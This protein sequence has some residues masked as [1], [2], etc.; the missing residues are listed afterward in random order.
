MR[1]LIHFFESAVQRFETAVQRR[2]RL[3]R[4]L[5]GLLDEQP[6]NV[7]KVGD[8]L[9]EGADPNLYVPSITGK[10]YTALH[11]ASIGKNASLE[12]VNVLLG[13]GANPFQPFIFARREWRL[14]DMATDADI[15]ARLK[16]AEAE[17]ERTYGPQPPL[18]G[19]ACPLPKRKAA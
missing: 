19:A 16:V 17:F 9:R 11:R 7:A 3:T 15:I 13:A 6:I 10:R 12:A 18:Q 14:S 1:R 4:K 8:I 2:D 5:A